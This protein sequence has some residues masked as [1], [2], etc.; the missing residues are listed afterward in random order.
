MTFQE[1]K[2]KW[3]DELLPTKSEELRDGQWLMICLNEV[4]TNEYSRMV[5]SIGCV[6]KQVDCFYNDAIIPKTWGHL[7]EVWE[8]FPL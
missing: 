3:E 4:W 2:T 5:H 1:F 8:G 6:Q 7:E